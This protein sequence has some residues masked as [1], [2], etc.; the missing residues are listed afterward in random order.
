[1]MAVKTHNNFNSIL[2]RG[3]ILNGFKKA[4]KVVSNVLKIE[5]G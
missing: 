1:M 3:K 2:T 5:K 4:A